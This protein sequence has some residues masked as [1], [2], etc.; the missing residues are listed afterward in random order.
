MIPI[1]TVHITPG[2]P[3][4]QIHRDLKDAISKHDREARK[5]DKVVQARLAALEQEAEQ[6]AEVRRLAAQVR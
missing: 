6:L 2:K 1:A 5:R 4:A 3:G